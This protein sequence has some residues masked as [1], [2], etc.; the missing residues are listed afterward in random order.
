MIKKYSTKII[1]II[2]S[3]IGVTLVI[4]P[5]LKKTNLAEVSVP[6]VQKTQPAP[7]S[8]QI[9]SSNGD[10]NVVG[11]KAARSV[12]AV[13]P[14]YK[15][16]SREDYFKN[17]ILTEKVAQK[18]YQDSIAK[19]GNTSSGKLIAEFIAE[20]LVREDNS[21]FVEYLQTLVKDL[22]KQGDSVYQDL[23]AKETEM[24]SD[25]FKYLMTLNMTYMMDMSQT[26]KARV[27][28]GAVSMSYVFNPQGAP[29]AKSLN[30]TNG[31]ILMKDSELDSTE[32]YPYLQKGFQANKH[33][34]KALREYQARV[35][36]FFPE[37]A[38]QIF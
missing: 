34:P 17:K 4:R 30:I 7:D 27:F 15:F 11:N 8:D 19:Y 12:A 38:D 16:K 29:A 36:A 31:M 21:E 24:Q 13:L 20:S 1:I 22:N 28:G 6:A 18:L 26:Q 3:V 5:F 9:I 25:R 35:E 10:T 23:L 33:N 14:V 37:L 32:I 2:L